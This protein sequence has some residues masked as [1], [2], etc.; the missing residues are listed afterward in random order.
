MLTAALILF[1][2]ADLSSYRQFRFGM[3]RPAAGDVKVVSKRPALI[4]TM[5]WQPQR[6][7]KPDSVESVDLTFYDKQLFRIV[8]NYQR[9]RTEG[10]TI[11]DMVDS[12]SATYG[13]ATQPDEKVVLPSYNNEQVKVL[14]RWESSEYSFNLVHSFMAS[15]ALIGESKA[16]AAPALAAVVESA[17]LDREEA[18]GK[19]IAR[20]QK[21]AVDAKD[22]LEKARVVNKA[23]FRP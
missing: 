1:V 5:E 10:M 12:L 13:P 19:E 15:Y 2:A 4:E 18:P 11:E 21:E 17:R 3:E 22:A 16:L 8:V 9:V 14:A 23:G 20:N 6:Q 7:A